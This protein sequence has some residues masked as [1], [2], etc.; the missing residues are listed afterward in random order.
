MRTCLIMTNQLDATVAALCF[1]FE[2]ANYRVTLL[3]PDED[4][5]REIQRRV[6]HLHLGADI[7]ICK[8]SVQD[9]LEGFPVQHGM[10]SL[11]IAYQDVISHLNEWVKF[12]SVNVI[13]IVEESSAA[14]L[15]VWANA[16]TIVM[17]HIGAATVAQEKWDISLDQRNGRAYEV[18]ML[19]L[20][21]ASDE[22]AHIRNAT[23][24]VHSGRCLGPGEG[25]SCGIPGK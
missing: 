9:W 24:M 5:V 13:R 20:Y 10:S 12:P 25:V 11:L 22:A 15:P 16:N 21:L 23:I 1:R 8:T 19:A 2:Q 6:D 4:N 17:A 3:L 14:S 18:A 7:E